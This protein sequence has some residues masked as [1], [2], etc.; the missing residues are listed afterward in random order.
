MLAFDVVGVDSGGDEQLV[1]QSTGA[2][3]DLAFGHSQPS[4]SS[5][6]RGVLWVAGWHE[7]ALLSSPQMNEMGLAVAQQSVGERRV[8]DAIVMTEM[9]RGP[10]GGAWGQ[11]PKSVK[12]SAVA[13]RN[14]G[15]CRMVDHDV[16][17]RI[18]AAR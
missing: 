2:R 3:A 9:D 16:Q 14:H 13:D 1:K 11:G 15:R 17:C 10:V 6:G 18:V 12:T 8:V 4:K 7:Q 5:D